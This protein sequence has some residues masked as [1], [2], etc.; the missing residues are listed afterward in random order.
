VG[1]KTRAVTGPPTLEELVRTHH[2][3]LVRLAYLL[4]GDPAEAEDVVADAY[5]KCWPRLARR[6][7]DDPLAY[8]RRAVVNGV[9]S[10][11]R[12]RY[13]MRREERRR[14]VGPDPS[15]PTS[16]VDDH[17]ALIAAVRQL[18][19]GQRQVLAL[20]FLE[21]LSE[22]ETA[23]TLRVSVGT[24]KSR[25]ARGLDALRHVLS[26]EQ[27]TPGSSDHPH[28]TDPVPGPPDAGHRATRQRAPDRRPRPSGP[29]S[30][31]PDPG[32]RASNPTRPPGDG[33]VRPASLP[34][35]PGTTKRTRR[36]DDRP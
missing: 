24:V 10:W 30:G 18:P 1:N 3:R 5:A 11:Q 31:T 17:S 9:R 7:V 32:E 16:Q 14:R 36:L 35:E 4:C 34:G 22:Q 25:T 6:D 27:P 33:A 26:I 20:R 28:E 12:R 19:L 29:P 8:L 15:A 23:A 21:D 13:L 2:E